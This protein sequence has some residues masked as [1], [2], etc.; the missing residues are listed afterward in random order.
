[1]SYTTSEEVLKYLG[2]DALTQ[3]R[4]ETLGTGAATTWTASHNNLV[5]GSVNL[6]T[7][8]SLITTS[9]STNLDDGIITYT[10]TAGV[11]VSADFD[12][13]DV[14][15]S[16]LQSIISS[17]DALIDM[18]TGR[19]FSTTT[20]NVEYLNVNNEQ[21]TFFLNNYPIIT[22]SSVEQNTEEEINT[23]IWST[24]TQGL[25][26][27]YLTN[28]EDLKIGRIR[29]IQ[30]FPIPG[31]DQIKVTYDYGY[32]DTPALINELSKL[33][34]IRQLANSTVYK[35]IF[36][37]RDNYTPVRLNEIEARI[38]ELFRLFTKQDIS[39]I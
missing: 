27:D 38:E 7:G 21:K 3:V 10:G 14:P 25:G 13:S 18:R 1:M 11:V 19:S 15:D 37:G 36:M 2:K 34:S 12:Y 31:N 6:Y 23:P 4:A 20:G 5:T 29:F 9:Y 28:S 39:S 26:N 17:S 16:V 32:A 33:L 22:L 24:S 35:S 30:N 8:G